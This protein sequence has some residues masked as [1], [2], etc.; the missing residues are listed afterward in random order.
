MDITFDDDYGVAIKNQEVSVLD[1]YREKLQNSFQ[2]LIQYLDEYQ[3][4]IV[5]NTDNELPLKITANAGS[6]KTQCLLAK[7]LKMVIQD[8]IKP[9]S[10]VLITFTNRA[11]DEIRKRYVDFFRNFMSEG[12]LMDI[13][14][15]HMSTIHSFS[16]SILYKMFGVRRTILTEYHALKLLKSI[17]L[18]VL[19]LKKI[20]M[21][22]VKDMY[23]IIHEIYANNFLLYFC[24]PIFN[25]NG[26]LYKIY[27]LDQALEERKEL[28]EKYNLFTRWGVT[29]KL[30]GDQSG[31]IL[32]IGQNIVDRYVSH[33]TLTKKSFIKILKSFIERKYISNTI[34]FSDMRMLPFLI[35]N[36]HSFLRESIWDMYKYFII[37][38]AQDV[39]TL[40][41]SLAV[42]C[43]KD[44]Y[45][46]YIN[47]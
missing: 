28:V 29:Q 38:E 46:R 2:Y 11:A 30:D 3:L 45:N 36:Q 21:K 10:I 23:D 1:T 25:S 19:E 9:S 26:T 16:C 32:E 34:D 24:L 18:E 27:D 13:S 17:I 33:T 15:P 31:D 20:E 5:Q 8:K 6:G 41:F 40:D 39:N 42:T 47:I 22:F 35:L 4:N 37:D 7:S 14:L 44:S 43:D 12:E